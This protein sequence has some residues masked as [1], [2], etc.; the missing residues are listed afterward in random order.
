MLRGLSYI[1]ICCLV[2]SI[3]DVIISS[4]MIDLVDLYRGPDILLGLDIFILGSC[5]KTI[6]RRASDIKISSFPRRR[7]VDFTSFA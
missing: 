7:Y 6:H 4:S 2:I 1:S 5:K 3:C